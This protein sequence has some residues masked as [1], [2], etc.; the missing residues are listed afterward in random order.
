MASATAS[1]NEVILEGPDQFHTWISVIKGS[2]P[3]DLWR[4]FDPDTEDEF[5]EPEPVTLEQ[6]REGAETL[7]DLSAAERSQ[8]TT[9][10]TIYNYD[11]TQFQRF[12]SEEAKLRSKIF[13]TV[14]ESKKAQLQADIS[15]RTWIAN[16]QTSTR[17]SNAQMK[18]ITRARHRTLLGAKYMDWPTGGP[19]KWLTEW[20]KLMTDCER[21]CPALYNDWASDFNLV[22]GE[23]PGAKRLCDRL[24]EAITNENID[25]W[26]IYRASRELKQAW[27]QKSI[28]SGMKVAGKGRVTRTAFAAEPRFDGDSPEGLE[29]TPSKQTPNPTETTESSQARSKSRKRSRSE[30]TQKEGAKRGQKKKKKP[31]WGCE[32]DHSPS[33]CVLISGHNPRDIQ[34]PPE[35]RQTFE[36]KMKDPSFAGKIKIIRDANEIKRSLAAANDEA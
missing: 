1:S 23:V 2:V 36:E 31:C 14:S 33:Q 20:Q 13:S 34:V 3:R 21:W 17:P 8:Y 28:R 6:L 29:S 5:L 35:C 10:R 24:V 7:A 25:E 30:N 16:L 32:G 12:L 26:N 11:M 15:V 19:D 9:L 4:Y 18:D 22:W 27:D